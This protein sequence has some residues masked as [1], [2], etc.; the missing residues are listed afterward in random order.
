MVYY[1]D[2]SKRQPQNKKSSGR[3]AQNAATS[4]K[5]MVSR[6][7][8]PDHLDT[9]TKCGKNQGE[10][11][12]DDQEPELRNR[13][14]AD[15]HHPSERRQ[16]YRQ[17]LRHHFPLCRIGFAIA[18][19]THLLPDLIQSGFTAIVGDIALSSA[20]FHFSFHICFFASSIYRPYN[21]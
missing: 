14:R 7:P 10:N 12:H 19:N 5:K 13:N 15:R 20:H 2:V 11:E 8:N 4:P 16:G 18:A 3:P 21:C 9:N 6:E 17:L 1:T